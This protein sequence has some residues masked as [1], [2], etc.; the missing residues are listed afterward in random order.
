M[1]ANNDYKTY[2]LLNRKTPLWKTLN[3]AFHAALA[4]SQRCNQEIDLCKYSTEDKFETEISRYPVILLHGRHQDLKRCYMEAI[5]ASFESTFFLDS[6]VADSLEAQQ[7]AT[8]KRTLDSS[9]LLAVSIYGPADPLSLL[10]KRMTL[11]GNNWT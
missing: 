5:N 11:L 3:G 2:I 7:I 9:N 4:L 1:Y 8:M 10:T 6:M